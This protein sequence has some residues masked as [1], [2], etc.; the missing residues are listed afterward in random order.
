[1]SLHL[2]KKRSKA[3]LDFVTIWLF[4]FLDFVIV[5]L[6]PIPKT[7][8]TEMINTKSSVPFHWSSVLFPL[9][10]NNHWF[11]LPVGPLWLAAIGPADR[12][13][14]KKDRQFCVYHLRCSISCSAR[15]HLSQVTGPSSK[16]YVEINRLI[17]Y[18]PQFLVQQQH[19]EA[20][21]EP[22]PRRQRQSEG[23]GGNREKSS[24]TE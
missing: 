21:A 15:V 11:S 14:T 5:L 1:M 23:E 22:E 6:I 16:V 19:S 13:P 9:A 24:W 2:L 8:I 7:Y 18:S 4:D 10:T 12:G 20:V 3:L 17:K